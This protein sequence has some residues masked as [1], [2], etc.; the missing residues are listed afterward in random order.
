MV[1]HAVA[2]I[3]PVSTNASAQSAQPSVVS[4]MNG[5]SGTRRAP[6][7]SDTNVRAS[8]SSRATNMARVP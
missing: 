7:G 6:A 3:T 8:G 2:A 4:A 1:V 5:I